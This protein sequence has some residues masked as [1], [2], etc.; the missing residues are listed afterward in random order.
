MNFHD[1]Y[2][3]Q[4]SF[5][6]IS[7]SVDFWLRRLGDGSSVFIWKYLDLQRLDHMRSSLSCQ[8]SSAVV[9]NQSTSNYYPICNVVPMTK[10]SLTVVF[11]LTLWGINTLLCFIS[12]FNFDYFLFK[13]SFVFCHPPQILKKKRLF[14]LLPVAR[15]CSYRQRTV[16]MVTGMSS[17][18]Q[19]SPR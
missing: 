7:Y 14:F 2:P 16:V 11:L 10:I 17:R 5:L 4:V 8:I 12:N 15:T 9:E 18:K 1:A 19:T 6:Y 13:S 3:C